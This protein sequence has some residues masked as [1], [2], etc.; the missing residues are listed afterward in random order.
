VTLPESVLAALRCQDCGFPLAEESAE[1]LVCAGS[2]GHRVGREDGFLTFA[3]PDAGKY[4][5]AYAARYAAL[6]AFGYQ[7]LHSG[8][9]ETLYRAV[10]SLAAESLLALQAPLVLDAGCGVGRCATDCARMAP[11][12]QVLALDASPAM[13][14]LARRLAHGGEPVAV[15]L[16]AHGFAEPIVIAPRPA[17]NLILARG[18]VEHLPLADD[19]LDLALSI[20]MIDRLPGGPDL[21]LAECYRVL[22]PGGRLLFSDPLNFT[23]RDL[24]ERFPDAGAILALLGDLGFTIETWF[25]DLCYRELL[26]SRR[27]FQE[28]NTLVVAARKPP[29]AP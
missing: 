7:T 14:E 5:Q 16:G 19:A 8:L 20:N 4:D 17:P 28:F 6:W 27:S 26:D 25:D 3:R 11:G 15:E 24:W 23:A 29:A 12:S 13:L 10:T 1:T 9:D 21:A 22:K 2:G 18:D